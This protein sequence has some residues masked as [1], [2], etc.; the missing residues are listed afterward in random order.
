MGDALQGQE[1]RKGHLTRVTKDE[2]IDIS[3]GKHMSR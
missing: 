3:R 1:G 2:G